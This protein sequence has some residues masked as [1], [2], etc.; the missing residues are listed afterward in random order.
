MGHSPFSPPTNEAFTTLPEGTPDTLPADPA[1]DLTEILTW[2]VILSEI[3][4]IDVLELDGQTVE[5]VQDA[6]LT[7]N[8]APSCQPRS[9]AQPSPPHHADSSKPPPDVHRVGV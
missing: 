7:V 6:S 3:F 5:T 2:H 9:L 4:A 8:V 1:G